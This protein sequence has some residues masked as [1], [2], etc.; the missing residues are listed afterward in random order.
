MIYFDH[1]AT[2]PV[3]QEVARAVY[4]VMVK[5]YGNPSSLHRAGVEAEKL[6]SRSREQIAGLLQVS[7]SS[8]IFTSGGSESNN[9]AIRGV[10]SKWRTRGKHI[11]TTAVEHSSVYDTC[12]A[13]KNNGYELTV[14]PVDEKGR[15]SAEQVRKAIRDDTILVSIMLVNNETGAIQPIEEIA[16]VLKSYPRIIFHVDAV[17]AA[18]KIPVYPDKWGVDLLSL[19]AHKFGGPK[20]IGLLYKR[21]GLSIDPLITGG[22][23][24]A[25]LRS[26][27]ENVPSI[28][29][30]AKAFRLALEELEQGWHHV[31]ELRHRLISRLENI[32]GLVI[33]S[34][35]D[36][37][38]GVPHIL[39][40]SCLGLKSEVLVHALEQRGFC[41][42]S[43]SACSTGDDKPSRVLLALG[44]S[45]ERAVSGLRISIAKE[46]TTAQIDQ[47][48]EALKDA[49]QELQGIVHQ[50]K[51]RKS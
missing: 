21:E 45:E 29:G 15:V 3:H 2:T 50:R 46:H 37:K 17:Q 16:S 10:A 40:V 48:A 1:S 13:L 47:L 41:I 12:Q 38:I 20:G 33:N 49:V 5:Y 51:M 24:E 43:R 31:V 4:E 28:V 26:G 32:P 19:S 9:L 39:N 22:G 27:T 6:L 7:K 42:S 35:T 44:H 8:I 30:M 34:P 25:G 11:I 23:Q 18:G 36:E 14:L